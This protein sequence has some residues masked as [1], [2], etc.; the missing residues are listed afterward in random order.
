MKLRIITDIARV[1]LMPNGWTNIIE[2]YHRGKMKEFVRPKS[3]KGA[4]RCT[5]GGLAGGV[6]RGASRKTHYVEVVPIFIQYYSIYYNE[7]F[8]AFTRHFTE[9][10]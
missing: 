4:E 9:L 7:I 2:I 10:I 3:N 5:Q 6:Y 1:L 8:G